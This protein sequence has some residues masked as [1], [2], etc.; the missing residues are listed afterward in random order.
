MVTAVARPAVRWGLLRVAITS[1]SADWNRRIAAALYAVGV[2]EVAQSLSPT[3]ALAELTGQ[4]AD[5]LILT[6]EPRAEIVGLVRRLRTPGVT[7]CPHIQMLMLTEDPSE[8]TI[9][10]WVRSGVDYLSAWPISSELV[11]G[12]LV[13]LITTPVPRISVPSY[14]GPDRRRGPQLAY[15]GAERRRRAPSAR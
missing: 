10:F 2:R 8:A 11:L 13:R 7:P 5:I 12:R 4:P 9:T 3:Q 6:T 15:S 14:I 1:S